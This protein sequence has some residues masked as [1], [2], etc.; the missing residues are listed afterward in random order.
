MLMNFG[1]SDTKKIIWSIEKWTEGTMEI[2]G[3]IP[4]PITISGSTSIVPLNPVIITSF[5]VSMAVNAMVTGLIVFKILKVFLEVKPTSVEGTLGSSYSTRGSK[6][7][8]IIFIIIESGMAL[9]AV[10]LVRVVFSSLPL[11][12]ST[13]VAFNFIIGTNQMFNVIIRFVHFYFFCFTD[14]I[15]LARASHQR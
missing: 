7:Q 9:F 2:N 6:L 13:A 5:T 3:I 12:M 1:S 10:Q 4:E 15:Y 11:M 8:H 14:N